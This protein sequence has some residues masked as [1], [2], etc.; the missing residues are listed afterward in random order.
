MDEFDLQPT[1]VGDRVVLRPLVPEDWDALYGCACDPLLWAGHPA[2]DRWKEP[3]FRKFFANAIDSGGALVA[4]RPDDGAV[5]GTS[6]YDPRRAEPGEMEIGWTF[7]VRE[8]WGTGLNAEM[9]R[10]MLDH[11]FRYGERVVFFVGSENGRSRR[12]LEKIGAS[13]TDRTHR[14]GMAGNSVTHLIYAIERDAWRAAQG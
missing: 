5:I 10:L 4:T 2:Q 13:L 1:L 12:A 11:A 8:H 6:R 9:K 14:T 3:V 7:L